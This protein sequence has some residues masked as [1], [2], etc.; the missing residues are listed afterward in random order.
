[1]KALFSAT[2]ALLALGRPA[3]AGQVVS[4]LRMRSAP[5]TRAAVGA[6]S[7]VTAD[8]SEFKECLRRLRAELHGESSLHTLLQILQ[9]IQ[10]LPHRKRH[11]VC[12]WQPEIRSFMDGSPAALQCLL[13]A[14]FNE[15]QIDGDGTPY[16]IM[17]RVSVAHLQTL[18]SACQAELMRAEQE[19][20]EVAAAEMREMTGLVSDEARLGHPP[21]LP[22]PRPAPPSAKPPPRTTATMRRSAIASRR[23]PPP[24]PPSPL[25]ENEGAESEDETERDGAM[26]KQLEAMI[27]GLISEL[28]RHGTSASRNGTFEVPLGNVSIGE[29]GAQ[30]SNRV[31]VHYRVYR[32]PT[33]P[34]LP[35][36]MGIPFMSGGPSGGDGDEDGEVPVLE[37]RLRSACLPP[38]AEE[39]ATRELKRLRRMSPMHSEYS[40]LIDYLEWVAD[41]P[42][43]K[44]SDERLTV[45][46]AKAQLDDDHYG[47]EKVKQRILEFLA[48]CQLRGDTK[49]SIMCMV[50]PPGIGKTS[51]GK[52]IAAA[53]GRDFHRVSLGGIHSEAEVRGHRRTYVGALPGLILQAIKKCGS[54]NA[55]I[56]LDEVDKL[57][58]NSLNGDPSSALLEV[59]DPEQNQAFRDH[60]LALPFNLSRVLFIATANE[61]GDIPRPL[62]DRMEVIEMHGYTVEEKVQIAK[63]HLLRKQ[64]ALHG[65]RAQQLDLNDHIIDAL[66]SGYTMEA[67]VREL[68]RQ[69]ASLCRSVAASVA[70]ENE[71]QRL[72]DGSTPGNGETAAEP[73]PE[74]PTSN[75]NA[76]EGASAAASLIEGKM[77]IEQIESVLGP[78][79]FDSTRDAAQRMTMPGTV[80]GLAAMAFGGDILFVEAA[81]MG[82]TGKLQLTGQLGDVMQESAKAAL[83]WIR[84]HATELGLG[85]NSSDHLLTK[86]DLHL[87]FPA[88]AIPK[89]GPSAGV[90]ITTAMVSSLTGRLVRPDLAMTGEVTLRGVVLPVGGIKEKV[91]AAHRAGLR[92][93]VMPAKN[94][95]DL[96]DLPASV[97]RDMNFTFVTD[98]QQVLDV[99]L[100]PLSNT[101]DPA[102]AAPA[103]R[104]RPTFSGH[105]GRS[106]S[107]GGDAVEHDESEE[108][109][110]PLPPHV[111]H[112]PLGDDAPPEPRVPAVAHAKC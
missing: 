106:S 93:V 88:G 42:W 11:R 16:L 33:F 112:T 14:G 45:T 78:P 86:T 48:V 50:G 100:L 21:S 98:V 105:G 13:T 43:N 26:I 22:M 54:N 30:D 23:V 15:Q 35:P 71:R 60:F 85:V 25:P 51:L 53:L 7:G 73:E 56:M 67:G 109:P 72:G 108:R 12:L 52:S 66:I 91:I 3:N 20:L 32:S 62:R 59:L 34:G 5:S 101:A 6:S 82:G 9:R 49:G 10:A 18:V 81:Q 47:M 75:S 46:A 104:S 69:L 110:L 89:D 68:E 79:K 29:G 39:V 28:E 38:E 55:V 63:R 4:I 17:R 58:R 92:T 36:S 1:M 87:H 111:P 44:S 74:L 70:E 76:E 84:A 61:L 31:P 95:K 24:A 103:D 40:T 37:R 99:A 80:I 2:L 96:R 41:L 102:G 19:Q 8:V 107:S 90:T 64:L 83:S 27:S 65:L 57:G 97:F 94:E 77:E